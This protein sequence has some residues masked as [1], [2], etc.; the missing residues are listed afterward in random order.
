MNRAIIII[1]DSLGLGASADA[2][3]YG[4][5]NSDTFGHIV[6][7]CEAGLANNA[8]RQG[9]LK[10]PN[11]LRW[12]LGAAA[13]GSRKEVLPLATHTR[14]EGAYGHAVEV[15]SGKDTPSGHWEICGL[16]VP[17]EW[18]TFPQQENCF[19]EQLLKDLLFLGNI[20]GTLANKHGS[21]TDVLAQ[22]GEEH[23]RTGY[24]ICYTSA[25]S[26]FQ[27]AAHEDTFGLERLYALCEVAK[28]LVDPLNVTRVIARP[29]KGTCN[30]D[31]ERTA[32]RK[33]LTTPPIGP[34]LL[35]HIQDQQGTVV[36]VGKIGDIFAHKGVSYTVKAAN[37]M[38]LVDQLLAQMDIVKEGLL[39][40]NLV[41]FDSKYGHRRNV[42]GYANA[43]EE[44]DARLPEIEANLGQ[45][46]L[47]LLSADH[48]CDPTWPGSDHTREHVPVVF[49]GHHC[50]APVQ[51]CDLGERA[52]FAD[53]GQT[54]AQHLNLVPLA[55]GTACEL[56]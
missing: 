25:D 23:L 15:S 39:F 3:R 47:V 2:P 9:P 20:Q 16:P 36:S 1:L 42:A 40:V 30:A 29:F 44:F 21:G 7:A 6:E 17:F 33:D 8:Q 54:V 55:Y 41:D 49:Y 56:N 50:G 48:G 18:G 4:D 26:V 22:Y 31:F 13:V 32:N 34:T 51:A 46:D 12:G 35:D 19:P 11:L 45:Q 10:I 5:Q 52:T 53:M 37:N 14:V 38:S 24:P 27:I 28:K 43:L